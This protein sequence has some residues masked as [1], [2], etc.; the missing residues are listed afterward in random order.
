MNWFLIALLAPALWSICNHIDKYLIS[1]YFKGS[2]TGSLLIFSS[3]IGV[4]VLP[5]IFVFHPEV[6]SIDPLYGL[7]I[8][9]NGA[10]YI[11]ALIPYIYALEKDEASIVMPLYQTVPIFSYILAFIVLKE[12]LTTAQLLASSLI[13]L[14]AIFI[15]LDLSGKKI[16]FKKQVFGL[17]LL[18]SF[19]VALNGLIFKF[20]AIRETFWTTSFWEYIG[21]ATLAVLLF[22]FVKPYRR[23]FLFVIKRNKI[24]VIGLNG[25][26]EVI[27]VIGKLSMNFAMLLTP[28]A[29]AWV[30]NG[31]QPFFVLF[32]GII[33]TVFFP[34]L[35][36]EN[37]SKKHLSQKIFAIAL[38]FLGSYLLNG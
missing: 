6:L 5:I 19:L 30:V 18:S 1:K 34:K 36:N 24:P 2:G 13:I 3:L 28:L 10:L 29:L 12:S 33:L 35:G 37:L 38:M 8:A 7:L 17:V 4:F 21:F 23:Q 11:L 31:F 16:R 14:G 22:T 32:Y 27:N 9:I 25:F 26:N 15:T 20:V